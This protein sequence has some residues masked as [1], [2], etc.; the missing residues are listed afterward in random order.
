MKMSAEKITKKGIV[1]SVFLALAAGIF[2]F[3]GCGITPGVTAAPEEPQEQVSEVTDGDPSEAED[4]SAQETAPEGSAEEDAVKTADVN[5]AIKEEKAPLAEWVPERP[6]EDGY[7]WAQVHD[8]VFEERNGRKMIYLAAG[9]YVKVTEMQGW[10]MEAGVDP[11]AEIVDISGID[12]SD[13]DMDEVFAA[14]PNLQ[15]IY[16]IDCG[17]DNDGYAKLQDDHPDIRI[18]WEIVLSHWTIRTDVVAFSSLKICADEFFMQN[19][20]AYYLKYCTDLVALDLGHNYVSDLTFLE[21]MPNLKIL[22]LVD[23]VKAVEGER[24]YHLTDL[25]ELQYVPHLRYLE[26]FANNVS[27]FSFMQYLTELEDL[28]ISYNSVSSIE[29]MR[30]LPHLQR[31][32]MEHT[33]IPYNE[34]V[35]LTQ[36]YPNAQIVYVGEGSI[37]QGWRSGA[38]YWAMRNMVKN[39]V[40]DDIYK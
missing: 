7:V 19:E 29:Y 5:P 18:I 35:E 10:L 8:D 13:M 39:N 27:D 22:I 1:E 30:N 28:N 23:N 25:S 36:L 9:E 4:R 34:Y 37:D 20:E 15:R 33:Y 17:L 24:K 3:T 21:Y 2:C 26:F 12:V 32:W 40:I 6:L 31:L 38:H 11:S 14:L 16:M